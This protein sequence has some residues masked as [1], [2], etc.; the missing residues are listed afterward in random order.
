MILP[1]S[2]EDPDNVERGQSVDQDDQILV[3]LVPNESQ[4]LPFNTQPGSKF[5]KIQLKENFKLF[6]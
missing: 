1:S 3:G 4:V 2:V 6:W 5:I